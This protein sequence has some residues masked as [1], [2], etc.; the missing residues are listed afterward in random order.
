M[1]KETSKEKLSR[2]KSEIEARQVL[3]Q[4]YNKRLEEA[5]KIGRPDK[6]QFKIEE[7]I[8]YVE[9]K[10]FESHNEI[11]KLMG[12]DKKESQAASPDE[13]RTLPINPLLN[14][15]SFFY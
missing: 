15:I 6:K 11:Q 13:V 5:E 7:A 10:I 12:K 3:L 9:G 8:K 14:F 2:L 4:A 1:E